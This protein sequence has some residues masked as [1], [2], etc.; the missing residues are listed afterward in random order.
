MEQCNPT[1]RLHIWLET[2]R[3]VFFGSGRAQLLKNIEKYGSLKKAAE[4]MGMSY[5]AAWGKIR[6][7]EDILGYKLIA[8][9]G[10]NRRYQ[11][12]EFG[13]E[14]TENFQFWFDRVE[15][16]ALR[17]AEE[18]FPWSIKTYKDQIRK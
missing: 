11:L 6:K 3:G 15:Q 18:I 16:D 8:K 1:V 7:T 4:N 5:R 10:R 2:D 13:K 17:D 14:L 12:T 9:T